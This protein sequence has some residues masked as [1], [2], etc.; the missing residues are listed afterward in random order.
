MG[1]MNSIDKSNWKADLSYLTS[2]LEF[3]KIK[4]G[5]TTAGVMLTQ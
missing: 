4:S 2:Y 3:V 5:F 1:L